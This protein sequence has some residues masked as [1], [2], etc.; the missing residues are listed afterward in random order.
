MIFRF[1]INDC[2]TNQRQSAHTPYWKPDT[3]MVGFPATADIEG[4]EELQDT[5]KSIVSE[6]IPKVETFV[7]NPTAVDASAIDRMKETMASRTEMCVYDQEMQSTKVIHFMCYHKMRVRLLVHFYAFLFFEDWR[8]DTWSKR[9]VRDHLRYI[10]ELQCAAA[11]VVNAI[12]ERARNKQ[13]KNIDGIFDSM[14]I[15][16]G[17][18]QYKG[19]RI[20]AEEL[21][22]TSSDLI[23]AGTTVYIATDERNKSFFKPLADKYDVVYL[24]DF[25]HLIKGINT[26]YYGMLDQ[27]IASRG[28]V[29]VGT[30]FSTFTGFINRMR[31]YRA[32][33]DKLSHSEN[34]IIESYYFVPLNKKYIMKKYSPVKKAFYAREFPTAWRDIDKGI[35]ELLES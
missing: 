15:R 10:D 19:T 3:C 25:R 9:F 34:G 24:D 8:Q 27:L 21:V 7:N 12:R 17:D 6:G 2:V 26:N 20:D 29:F 11:R 23:P 4:T 28:R 18:F 22:E 35:G 32:V 30:Y 16:R 33:K 31:G 13:S 5:H 14:H 1:K